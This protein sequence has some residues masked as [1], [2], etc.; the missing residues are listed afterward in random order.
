MLLA[1]PPRLHWPASAKAATLFC[2]EP[3]L[4]RWHPMNNRPTIFLAALASA[5]IPIST[6]MA[7]NSSTSSTMTV[8]KPPATK[9]QPV[10]DDYLGHKVVDPYRWLEDGSSPETQ[11]WVAEQLAYTRSVLDK[12]PGRDQ[13]HT[14]SGA[15]AADRQP[16]RHRGRRR[17]LLPHPP[18]R[19]AEPAGAVCP[20]GRRRQ[21]RSAGRRER[22]RQGRHGRARLVG[23]FARRQVRCLRHLD[24]RLGDQHAARHRDRDAQAAA[25]HHRAHPRRQPGLEARRQRLLLHA[26]SQAGRS[27]RRA[28]DVQ[29]PRL[30]SPAGRRSGEGRADFRRRPRSA[31]LAQRRA[32]ERRPLAQHHG[33]AGLD[34][35]RGLPQGPATR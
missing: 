14:T 8:P 35:E 9:Q 17:V 27:C 13:L 21:R 24:Q 30:L 1:K 34:E 19:H 33:R 20:Q 16:G 10:T 18:R 32:L 26:L 2:C 5:L 6:A 7:Q 31:G 22:A 28:G 11:H 3:P 4:S 23:T 29:P 25:R 15:V 12:L